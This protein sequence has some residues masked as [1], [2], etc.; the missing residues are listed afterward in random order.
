MTVKRR[1]HKF[2][3]I[4]AAIYGEPLAILPDKLASISELIELS[5]AGE[6]FT[7]EEIALRI[8]PQRAAGRDLAQSDSIAVL[9]LFGVIAQRS[10][11]MA[12]TSGGTSTIAYGKVFDEALADP[13]VK[14][15]VLNVDSPGGSVSG[16]SELASKIYAARGQK[17]IIAVAN[18]LMASAAYWIASAA[19]EVVA[20]PSAYVGSI[21]VI[22]MHR[23]ASAAYKKEGIKPTII[24]AGKYKAEANDTGPLSEEALAAIQ[25]RV[26]K[27]YSRFASAVAQHRSTQVTAVLN[28]YGQ[29]RVLNAD[30]AIQAGLADKVGT[31]ESVLISLGAAQGTGSNRIVAASPAVGLCF[32]D[33]TMNKN[34]L[35]ALVKAG[36]VALADSEDQARSALKGYCAAKGIAV[37]ATDD[38]ALALFAPA[39]PVASQAAPSVSDS[40]V[41]DIMAAVKIAR[42]DNG[43][44]VA[45]SLISEKGA[46]GQPISLQSC[47][48]KIES[49]VLGQQEKRPDASLGDFGGI[50]PGASGRDAFLATAKE[51]IQIRMYGSNRPADFK[52]S[53][54]AEKNRM[55]MSLPR[56][57]EECLVV[58]G[59]FD[60]RKVAD[61]A[62][63]SPSEFAAVAL[64]LKD[65]YSMGL[66][67]SSD[68]P[69]YNVSG[70]FSN[71]LLDAQNVS[72]RRSYLEYEPTY[73]QVFRQAESLPDFKTAYATIAGE[74]PDPKAIAED[75]EFEESTLSDSKE[76]YKLSVWGEVFSISWQAV[77]NDRLGSFT[78]IPAK[79]GRAMRRK[80]NKLA[81][82]VFLDNAALG[83]D[84]IALF[85]ASHTNLTTGAGAPSV[86]TL[87][88]L[89]Q[90]MA[91]QGGI[92]GTSG[93]ALGLMPKWLIAPPALR[94][95]VLQLLGSIADPA[96]THAGVKN[97]WENALQP[98]FEP[99]LG[100]TYGGSDVAWYLSADPRDVDTVV[101]AFL[102]GLEMPAMDQEKAFDRLALR[103]RIYQPFAVKAIDYRGLQKHAGA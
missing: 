50:R 15:I 74:L 69:A 32:E 28:G 8:G 34:L 86:A 49:L 42:L 81:W 31:L 38:E 57:A 4:R 63:N 90:K 54:A 43:L 73:T 61:L 94:G 2:R 102:K 26:D 82:G 60:R 24:S 80:Q 79:Q 72:L 9:D 30:D 21:G 85:H 1:S 100:L 52:P 5:I 18:S 13:N 58:L 6:R 46:D 22:T 56:L 96:A 10:S 40:R 83:A 99:Q 93:T 75:G 14:A 77:V 103:Y 11:M 53:A 45:A 16:V 17:P 25:D 47:L 36:I 87:N 3:R 78:E 64:G 39:K 95:T 71:I 7:A 37:P 20:A 59:G 70:G 68:G 66:G 12:E 62:A 41:S 67:A 89:T 27:A 19:D 88:T 33:F 76:S 101:Y 91:E 84:S 98:V 23:D 29:G 65:G 35:E 55:L 92:S 97:I 48:A 51:A 44:E